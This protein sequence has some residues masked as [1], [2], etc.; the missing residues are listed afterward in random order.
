[1]QVRAMWPIWEKV[2]GDQH[3]VLRGT[4]GE[5]LSVADAD[6]KTP[7]VRVAWGRAYKFVGSNHEPTV[8]EPCE[9][10]V[11]AFSVELVDG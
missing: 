4:R 2:D 5:L 3:L 1:M 9:L 10:T 7:Q 11:S 6:G 8:V